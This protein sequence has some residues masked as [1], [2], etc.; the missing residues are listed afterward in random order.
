LLF[1]LFPSW[2]RTRRIKEEEEK[3]E[4]D[5]DEDDDVI[6]NGAI[7]YRVFECAD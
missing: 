5:N 7:T 2:R 3:E 1:L 6:I 4:E